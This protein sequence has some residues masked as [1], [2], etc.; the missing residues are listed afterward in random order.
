MLEHLLDEYARSGMLPMH[1]PGH[2]RSGAFAGLLPYSLDITEIE[3]FDDLYNAKGVLAETMA[4][5]A[6][7]YGS[8]RAY[9]GV[10]GSTGC[11][12]A[13]VYAAAGPGDTVIVAR[14]CHRSVY[15][16]LEIV[17]ARPVFV[18]PE[19]DAETGIAG[20]FK[21]E[22]VEKSLE[23][24]RGARLVIVT[25][26]TYEG[27]VSDVRSICETAHRHGAVVLVD[28]A[29][30]AHLGFHPAFP[31][32]PVACGADM[33]AMS[34]HKTLPAMT[35][36]ALLHLCSERVDAQRLAQAMRM[37]CTSSPSYVLMAS[38]DRCLRLLESE[39]GALF[40]RYSEALRR[41]SAR[42]RELQ[43]LRVLCHGRDDI[44]RH[45][46]FFGFDPGKI[47]V[48]TRGAGLT[49]PEFASRLREAHK[50]ETEMASLGYV[51]AM[52]SVCDDDLVLTR[53]S[54]AL[55]ALD[56][57]AR[58]ER[59]ISVPPDV[60]S[61]P[62]MKMDLAEAAWAEG[63]F[64]PIKNAAGKAALEYVWAYPP[65]IPVLIPGETVTGKALEAL[66]A[67]EKSGVSVYSSR[68]GWPE[69]LYC[70]T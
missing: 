58:P 27:V 66:L 51:L 63:S 2:K 48:D 20:S 47:V 5:A 35:Q 7:L 65:G 61:L 42:A 13:A 16:A 8:R 45:S 57:A 55:F 25:S 33:V 29:H 19:V 34:L 15:H 26:P 28:A 59:E 60:F 54:D 52:T 49:G 12:L 44:G 62:E 46:A 41:F 10:N 6:R 14:N 23:S 39:G 56:G 4:L 38:I 37:F 30:G 11:I 50:I 64:V 17:R 21:P 70:V 18:M 31:E 24:A 9:L 32:S 1:T 40:A 53:L 69:G 43:H 36:T 68:G 67:L 3:G 22:A